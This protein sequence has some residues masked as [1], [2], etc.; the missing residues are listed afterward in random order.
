MHP[1]T[2]KQF[3]Q[4]SDPDNKTDD[5]DLAA[6]QRAAAGG[7]ALVEPELDQAERELQLVVRQRRDL[8]RKCAALRCQIL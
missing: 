6:I 3:R 5:T 8:V 4:P 1:F 7:F 2:T